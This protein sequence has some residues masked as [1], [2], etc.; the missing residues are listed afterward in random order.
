VHARPVR[1]RKSAIWGSRLVLL[2]SLCHK[3]KKTS[4]STEH[5]GGAGSGVT[6][7]DTV[8]RMEGQDDINIVVMMTCHME[9]RVHSM[10]QQ[11]E[12]RGEEHGK[13]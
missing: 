10:T 2:L 13:G 5:N 11:H 8:I 7:A 12:T 3:A 9:L 1:V 4:C 6:V